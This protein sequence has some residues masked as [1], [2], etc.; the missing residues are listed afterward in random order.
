VAGPWA[1]VAWGGALLAL[2][3]RIYLPELVPPREAACA[4]A[5]LVLPLAAVAAATR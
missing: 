5:L 4:V 2:A 1:L 3:G